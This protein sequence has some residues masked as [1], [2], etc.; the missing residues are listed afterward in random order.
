MLG[1]HDIDDNIM[2]N[3]HMNDT[4]HYELASISHSRCHEQV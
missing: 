3:M 4:A 2:V 1:Q